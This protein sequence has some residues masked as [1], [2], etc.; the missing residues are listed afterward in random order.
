MEQELYWIYAF[1]IIVNSVLS[2]FTTII[3]IELFMRLLRIKQP[4]AKGICRLLPFCKIC[5]DLCLYH[6]SNWALLQGINPILAETGTRNLS[7]MVNPFTGIQFSMQNGTTFSIADII[8]LSTSI[9]LVQ[10]VVSIAIT[11]AIIT[12]TLHLSRIFR[13]KRYID[14]I[15]RHSTAIDWPNLNHYL[16]E[17]MKQKGVQCALTVAVDTP[18]ITKKTIL[19]PARLYRALSKE[20]VEAIIAHEMGHFYWRDCNL[21]LTYSVIAS[22]FWWIPT[23]WW[24]RRIE[25]MQEQASDSMIHQFKLSKFALAEAVLKTARNAN[26]PSELS[27]SFVERRLS[28]KNRM[29]MI[30][31]EPK[32]R[33]LTWKAIQYGFLGLGLLSILFG[34]LWVF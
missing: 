24:Q 5:I 27:C 30:L 18:C 13:A 22:V 21:R 20:E 6:F 19:F 10:T 34:K 11:G 16:A 3:L 8:A 4:R 25:E 32:P 12:C 23:K 31:Q 14:R 29:K 2:F 9:L 1:N 17:W 28:L 15:V 7:I 33:T 26:L